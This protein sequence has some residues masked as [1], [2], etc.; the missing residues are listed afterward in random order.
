MR[1]IRNAKNSKEYFFTG[2]WRAWEPLVLIVSSCGAGWRG[3]VRFLAGHF[4][5]LLR[6]SSSVF[7]EIVGNALFAEMGRSMVHKSRGKCTPDFLAR[8]GTISLNIQ[9]PDAVNSMG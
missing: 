1:E 4:R 5:T 7:S 9:W 8:L 3:E 2:E 6:L